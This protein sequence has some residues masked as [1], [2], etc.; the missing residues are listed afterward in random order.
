MGPSGVCQT[1]LICWYHVLDVDEGIF[2]AALLEEVESLRNEFAKAC[3]FPLAVVDHVAQVL[4]AGLVQVQNGQQL[5]KHI[6]E[7]IS[8]VDSQHAQQLLAAALVQVEDGHQ[9]YEHITYCIISM[10]YSSPAH[11]VA[12]V[13]ACKTCMFS[14]L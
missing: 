2:S 14:W 3:G 5:S 9:L 10:P 8:R 13:Q 4:V 12:L 7:L 11:R 1:G 6:T